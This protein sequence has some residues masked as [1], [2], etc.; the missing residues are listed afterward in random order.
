MRLR[1]KVSLVLDAILGKWVDYHPRECGSSIPAEKIIARI[2]EQLTSI[3][4]SKGNAE[5]YLERGRESLD[6]VKSL[7]E[8]QDG[9]TSRLLTIIA[10]LT[11]AAGV[12]FSKILDVY[13]LQQAFQLDTRVQII[14][15][16]GVYG[17]FVIFLILVSL[18]SLV[19]FHAM[20][21]R[22]FWKSDE[23]REASA[24][25]VKSFLFFR[26]M[27]ATKPE[28]WADAFL[29]P[30]DKSKPNPAMLERYY[31]NYITECY[32]IAVKLADK[33][34]YLEPAQD[35]LLCS[36]KVLICWV[37][38]LAVVVAYVPTAGD[39][40]NPNMENCRVGQ[41]GSPATMV[42]DKLLLDTPVSGV[43]ALDAPPKKTTHKHTSHKHVLCKTT[44]ADPTQVPK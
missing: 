34:R 32:L 43:I 8:Y 27:V 37:I 5:E 16:S 10:F 22:F 40:Y 25:N 33:I 15:V 3:R 9:K 18:G 12:V 1:E 6:E 42:P 24:T 29:D 35:L 14:M 20:R 31:K 28:A 21:T 36:I 38:L 23:S 26:S 39:C 30:E 11:A 4:F 2:N 7:T 41:N 44:C 17:L 19:S 13:P